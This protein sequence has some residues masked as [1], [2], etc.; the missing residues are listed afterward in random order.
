LRFRTTYSGAHYNRRPFRLIGTL[1]KYPDINVGRTEFDRE[2]LM[3]PHVQTRSKISS[4][5]PCK[6]SF[7]NYHSFP[8]A[9][10]VHRTPHWPAAISS[11]LAGLWSDLNQ[12]R[13]RRQAALVLRG[14]DDH[15]L[16][17]IGIHRCEIEAVLRNGNRD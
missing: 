7:R 2:S 13:A 5:N 9:Q 15:T 12:W 6:T 16:R 8:T 3:F 4:E 14:L 11:T 10:A 17:D 1:R